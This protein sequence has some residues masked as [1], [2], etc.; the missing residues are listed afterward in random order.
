M[1]PAPFDY[2]RPDDLG[3]ALRLLVELGPEARPLAGGQSLIPFM[4]FRLARPTALI[5][6]NRIEELSGLSAQGGSVTVGA[7]ARQWDVE[8]SDVVRE[9]CPLLPAALRWVGHTATRARGTLGGSVAHADPAAEVPTVAVALGAEMTVAGANGATERVIPAADFFVDH[10]TTAMRP[11]ELLTSVRFPSTSAHV[12][13]DF[14]EFA[15]RAGDF[16]LAS[17]AVLLDVAEG[18]AVNSATIVLGGVASTPLRAANAE[19]EL[20]GRA[21]VTE[22]WKAAAQAA[23][24]EID[25]LEEP[26]V[27]AGYRRQIVAT[28]VED[29]LGN[30]Y[31]RGS[32]QSS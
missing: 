3:D 9:L 15:F 13:W 6:L 7:T 22:T 19:T 29:A 28:L 4:N 8:Q 30:A 16:A 12:A 32:E 26:D 1:K 17:V 14:T 5:D 31:A 10:Y 24:A 21:P 20:I 23:A 2:H 25:P 18:D 11:G 27:P